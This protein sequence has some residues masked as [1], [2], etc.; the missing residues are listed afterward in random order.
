MDI[1]PFSACQIKREGEDLSYKIMFPQKCRQK[2]HVF[3]FPG[4][5]LQCRQTEQ[6]AGVTRV[7]RLHILQTWF[8]FLFYFF[9]QMETVLG[10]KLAVAVYITIV[11]ASTVKEESLTITTFSLAH[12][13]LV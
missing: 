9:F 2:D 7:Q 13:H 4:S 3:L 1:A 10:T 11:V 12:S 6:L 8:H 5:T